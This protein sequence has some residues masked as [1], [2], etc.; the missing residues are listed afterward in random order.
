[1]REGSKDRDGWERGLTS[2]ENGKFKD[3]DC[4]E[5]LLI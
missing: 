3:S 4:G 2:T 5:C 1:M